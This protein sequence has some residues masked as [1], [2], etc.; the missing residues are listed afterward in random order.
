MNRIK[1]LPEIL[2]NKI[3]AGEIVERPASVVKELIEN[4][5]DAASHSIHVAIQSG[6]KRLIKVRDDGL[7]MTQDDAILAFEHHAT[8]KIQNVEDL[9][10]IDTLGFRGEALPSIASVSRLTL[11]TC[12]E[13]SDNAS[14]AELEIRGGILRSVK[15]ISWDRG[16]EISVR[17]LFF[18]VPARRKFL[19]TN[20]T[21]YG[22]IARNVTHYALVN[23]EIRFTLESGDRVLL[24]TV[25]VKTS[26]ERIYQVFGEKFLD[27][28]VEFSGSDGPI[29]LYGFSSQPHEQRTNAFSQYF[30]VN[31]RMVRDKVISGAVRQAYQRCMPAASYP[32]VIL[33]LELPYDLVDVNAHPAKTEIRFH[34]Q[35]AVFNLV[36][37]TIEKAVSKTV[38]I[39]EFEPSGRTSYPS[40]LSLSDRMHVRDSS[41]N[42]KKDLPD[43]DSVI[44][45]VSYSHQ[46][47]FNYP[48]QKNK[49]TFQGQKDDVAAPYKAMEDSPDFNREPGQL[50]QSD[51]IQI[52]GQFRNSYIIASDS[53][54]L[55]IVDQ[56]VAHERI[57]YEELAAS[58]K[59]KSVET[60]GLLSPI[61]ME[62]APHQTALIERVMPEL[63]SSGFGVE[64]FGGSSILIRSVPA[65][66]SESDCLELLK[67][68]IENLEAEDRN[69]DLEQIQ[70][71]IAVKTAC[72]AAVKINMPL[73][74]EKMQWLVDKLSRAQLP[75]SCPHGRPII[76]RFSNY[77]IEKKFG[78][79]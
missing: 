52:L 4:S 37:E 25:A 56:H 19:K 32:V 26:K 39:P 62:L 66:T 36:K 51:S 9:S 71:R 7:G 74:M 14:G 67:E 48:L 44:Q 46:H 17:D 11:K 75:T 53:Q 76:L 68:I 45:E 12:P 16:T 8:S 61:S 59:R 22:H 21:E 43:S 55:L 2:A 34:N 5:L 47:A 15:P 79:V 73:S 63:K 69:L 54:G 28:L 30:Y 18:N 40:T 50:L 78:R 57:L 10:S 41:G 70:D 42:T 20:E 27:N 60:Q 64:H 29:R 3:A 58:M 13:D 1:V 23:P 35:K 77:E 65:I 38:A 72:S 33:F 24:D 31:K 49:G 6:G